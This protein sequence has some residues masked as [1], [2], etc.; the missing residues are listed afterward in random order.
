MNFIDEEK[1][2]NTVEEALNGAMDII[3]EKISD[4]AEYR[5]YI[6]N[7]VFN[8]GLIETKGSS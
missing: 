3:S 5:K 8:E 1:G 4:V 7:L 2:V 6:R